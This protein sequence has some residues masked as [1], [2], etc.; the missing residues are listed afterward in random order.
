MAIS[1]SCDC[2]KRLNVKDE[3]DGRRIKCP[4]CQSSLLVSSNGTGSGVRKKKTGNGNGN[5]AKK[6]GGKGILFAIL[7]LGLLVGGCCCFTGV[8][9]GAWFLWPSGSSGLE[10]KIVGKWVTDMEMPK[11]GE[12]PNIDA[13]MN[14]GFIEFKADG[15]V[16]DASP[17]TPIM[18]GKWKTVSSQSDVLTVELSDARTSK[19]LDIKVVSSDKLAITPA[20]TK[21]E[22][23]FK[24]AS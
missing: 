21:K 19:K 20:D 13:L 22:F 6:G 10:K 18:Q 1:V 16:L 2:G 5:G 24:R 11:K 12:M 23:K 7:G 15:T 3:L 9:A 8:G 14:A 17:M 4:G